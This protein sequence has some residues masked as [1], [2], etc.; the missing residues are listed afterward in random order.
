MDMEAERGRWEGKAR[1]QEK[2]EWGGRSGEVETEGDTGW[3]VKM[4]A[5]AQDVEEGRQATLT[6]WLQAW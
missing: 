6:C 1:E 3:C 4:G 5:G 2:V